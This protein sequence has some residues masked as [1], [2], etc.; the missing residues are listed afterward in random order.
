MRQS[1]HTTAE[2]HKEA[3]G[4]DAC[5]N[6]VGHSVLELTAQGT[7]PREVRLDERSLERERDLLLAGIT[8]YH[9][10]LHFRVDF[11][12]S[13]VW[14]DFRGRISVEQVSRCI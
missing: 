10:A 6:P 3:V 7:D 1:F 11:V 14:L 13:P 2:E 9:K 8:V 4:L 12:L 5:D